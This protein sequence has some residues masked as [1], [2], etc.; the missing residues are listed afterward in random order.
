MPL[1]VATTVDDGVATLPLPAAADSTP[2]PAA[3]AAAAPAAPVAATAPSPSDCDR[4]A[5]RRTTARRTPRPAVDATASTTGTTDANGT[6]ASVTVAGGARA[7]AA[8]STPLAARV[9]HER[10]E[11]LADGLAARLR[12]SLAGD[13]ARVRMHLT[14]RELG[15]VV[16]RLELKDGLATRTSSPTPPTPARLLTAA[17]AD[18]RTALADRGLRLDSVNVRVAG[19]AGGPMHGHAHAHDQQQP[20]G[21]GSGA[22]RR[23]RSAASTPC[24][25][26][27]PRS[28]PASPRSAACPCSPRPPTPTTHDQRRR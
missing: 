1:T 22:P 7:E 14:P 23:S 18:L 11:R 16:V 21:T 15:E 20:P 24:G 28:P 26:S 17:M 27:R 12:V 10:F 9:D 2:A 4:Q 19:D 6:T 3:P 5:R 25:P 13:G 8:D